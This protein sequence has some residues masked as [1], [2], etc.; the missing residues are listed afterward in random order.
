MAPRLYVR[1]YVAPVLANESHSFLVGHEQGGLSPRL[2]GLLVDKDTTLRNVRYM[3]EYREEGIH[4]IRRTPLFQEIA[5]R[6]QQAP[7]PYGYDKTECKIKYRFGVVN[8][9]EN[10]TAISLIEED[11]EEEVRV[12]DFVQDFRSQDLVIVPVTQIGPEGQLLTGS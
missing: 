12:S 5:Y 6:C 11:K 4:N 1:L 3:I 9:A 2:E 10:P 7:N 8:V